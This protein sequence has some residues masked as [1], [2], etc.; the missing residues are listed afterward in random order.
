MLV[1]LIDVYSGWDLM[2]LIDCLY[3]DADYTMAVYCQW[4]VLVPNPLI[5]VVAHLDL[6]QDM[7]RLLTMMP[8][9]VD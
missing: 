5:F 4:I 2:Q 1:M 9:D 3:D 7:T 8:F 6:T